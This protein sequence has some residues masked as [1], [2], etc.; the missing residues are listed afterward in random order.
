MYLVVLKLDIPNSS[1]RPSKLATES[2]Y[3]LTTAGV[4]QSNAYNLK[5]YLFNFN[6]FF[7]YS[8]SLL[9]TL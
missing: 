3:V 8:E 5:F 1:C 9:K 7:K 6:F 4:Q 2:F